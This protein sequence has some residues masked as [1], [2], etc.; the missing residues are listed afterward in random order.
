MKF[1]TSLLTLAALSCS[2]TLAAE[3]EISRPARSWEFLGTVG[4]RSAILGRESGTFEAWVFPLKLIDD[5]RLEFKLNGRPIPAQDVARAVVYRPGSATLIYSGDYYAEHF[6]VRE[7]FVA[8]PERPGAVVRLEI[9]T[10]AKLEIDAVFRRDFTLMWPAGLGGTHESWD[11]DLGAAVLGEGQG[12]FWGIVGAPGAELIDRE[13]GS[14]YSS[15]PETRFR[16]GT[17]TE[18]AETA[19]ALTAS[20]ESRAQAVERFQG[21]IRDAASL[22]SEADRYF[23]DYLDNALRLELPDRKL[24][25]AYDWS[26]IS[27]RKGLVENPFMKGRGLVAG[28]GLSKGEPRPG[29]AWF[30]GRDSFWTTLALTA[31]G[32]FETARDAI[33]FIAQFQRDDGKIPHEISQSAAFV[34]WFEDY[35]YAYAAADATSLYVI[36]VADYVRAS[37]DLAF[38]EESWDRLSKASSFLASIEDANGFAKNEGVGHGWVEG[39]PLLPVRTEFY[40]A[41]LHVQALACLADLA[42]LRGDS[43]AAAR[44]GDQFP[45]KRAKLNEVY[46]L[47]DAKRYAFAI[48]TQGKAVDQPS[49]LATVPMWFGLA[50]ADKAAGMIPQL[51]GE[52]HLTDWGTRI[53]SSRS[54]IYGPAGYHFGSVWPLFTGWASVG[55]YRYHQPGPAYANLQANAALAL[56]GSGGNTTEVVSGAVYSPLSTSSSHQIWS[57]AMV[58]SP[59]VRGL[60]GLQIDAVAKRITLAPHLPATWDRF[61]VRNAAVPGGRAALE[62]ERTP[63]T[64]RLRVENSGQPFTLSFRPALA[65]PAEVVRASLTLGAEAPKDFLWTS[66]L[67]PTDWHPGFEFEVPTGASRLEI[68]VKNDFSLSTESNLPLFGTPEEGL[69]IIS[70]TW[71]PEGNALRIELRGA[72]GRTYRLDT[73]GSPTPATVEGAQPTPDGR[74]LIVAIP[75]QGAERYAGVTVKLSFAPRPIRRSREPK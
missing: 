44:F 69:R 67:T 2:S 52:D 59:I 68:A 61:A 66:D 65:L 40:Q 24:Q 27:M 31:G 14:N 23:A 28:F 38:L 57:A 73:F 8:P 42:K 58:V 36:A 30:F 64:I 74:A 22:A 3:L 20:F 47:P 25:E 37:G 35:P 18:K 75:N 33:R 51:A 70:Q 32:D 1:W 7:T 4:H 19:V 17:F 11:D 49:V 21:L 15:N 56:D 71:S 13:Y 6:L 46:W 62:M 55:Q 43:T 45:A 39:G 54:P 41:G 10:S 48:D 5:F 53:L 26:M 16:L 12:R 60:L 29:F 50:D 72:R 9:E 34:P 63:G